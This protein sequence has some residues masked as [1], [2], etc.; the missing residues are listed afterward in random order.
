MHQCSNALSYAALSALLVLRTAQGQ[1]PEWTG[2][3]P[4]TPPPPPSRTHT[5]TYTDTH[6]LILMALVAQLTRMC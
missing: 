3:D 6:A 4:L 2:P 5:H 1:S